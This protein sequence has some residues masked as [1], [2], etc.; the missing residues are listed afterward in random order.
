MSVFKESADI[1]SADMLDL[2]KPEAD[3]IT[4]SV[5]PQGKRIRKSVK[6]CIFN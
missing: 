3:F 4:I 5:E 2:P 1:K 6:I